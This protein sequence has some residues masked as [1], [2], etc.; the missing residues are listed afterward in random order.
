MLSDRNRIQ[1]VKSCFIYPQ[2]LSYG[3]LARP[4]VI[5]E[6]KVSYKI[7]STSY[8]TGYNVCFMYYKIIAA[9]APYKQNYHRKSFT[10]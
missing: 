5:P 3:D 2:K 4:G 10:N 1:S 6:K 7:E 8:Y 9:R